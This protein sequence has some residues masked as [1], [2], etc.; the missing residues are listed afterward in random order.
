M[1]EAPSKIIKDNSVSPHTYKLEGKYLSM[2][3]FR[4]TQV[5]KFARSPKKTFT[6]FECAR[7]KSLPGVGKYDIDKGRNRI[8]LGAR[9][10]RYK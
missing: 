8:T 9:A 1:K 6:D 5:Y 3:T 7:F 4:K 10:S 2:S